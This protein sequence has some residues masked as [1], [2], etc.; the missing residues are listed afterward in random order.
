MASH[1]SNEGPYHPKDAV[2]GAIKA[3]A[4]TGSAGLFIAAVQNTLARRPVGA[5]GVLTRFGGTVGVFGKFGQI[6]VYPCCFAWFLMESG[7]EWCLCHRKKQCGW[8]CV[9]DVDLG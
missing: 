2:G 5:A 1:S 7:F 4:I 9:L 8:L 6:V 3:T